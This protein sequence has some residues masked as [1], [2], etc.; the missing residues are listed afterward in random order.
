[1]DLHNEVSKKF[2][3]YMQKILDLHKGNIISVFIYGLATGKDYSPKVSDINSAFIFKTVTFEAMALSAK[4][5]AAGLSKRIA[6]PLF[7][8]KEHIQESVDV[9]PIEYLDMR[10]NH[11]VLFGEDVFEA[12]E[13]QSEH[14]RLFCEQ[15][16]KGKLI[17]I[18]QA[19]LETGGKRKYVEAV[20]KESLNALF[21]V[22]RNC[23]RLKGVNPPVVK[24][25]IVRQ[26]CHEFNLDDELWL[27]LFRDRKN[28]GRIKGRQLEELLEQY[29]RDIE[30]IATWVNRL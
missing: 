9:F 19:F 23:L 3:P 5:V 17:R 14:L 13:I 15:Q 18:R 20:L 8:T 2:L 4:W 6:A 21:P 25:M 11:K 28:D 30:K 29:L 10:E 1:M 24:E 16:L 26:V 27:G 22:I 7:L 12:I